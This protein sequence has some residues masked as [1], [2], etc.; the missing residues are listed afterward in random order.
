MKPCNIKQHFECN[1]TGQMCNVCG[2]SESSCQCESPDF[3]LLVLGAAVA[4]LAVALIAGAATTAPIPRAPYR[5]SNPPDG[6]VLEERRG[7]DWS[8]LL[9]WSEVD[10]PPSRPQADDVLSVVVGA[11]ERGYAA[12]IQA[13]R[14]GK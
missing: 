13:A 12:G 9:S 6:A 5:V 3:D 11:W 2:E 10:I 4:I 8:P 7:H 1:G 14:K